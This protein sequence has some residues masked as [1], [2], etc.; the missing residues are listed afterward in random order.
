M[1]IRSIVVA[2]LAASSVAFTGACAGTSAAP[3]SGGGSSSATLE[4][5]HA[6]AGQADKV[7]FINWALDT[8]KKEHP[9]IQ[10]KAVPAEQ[11]SYKTKLQTAMASG[12]PP[13]VFYSLPGGYLK[14]FVDSGQVLPLDDYMAKDGWKNTFLPSSLP[15]VSFN[16]KT[17]A[18]PIDIDSAVIWYDKKLFAA[19]GW[20]PPKTWEEFQ[21]LCEKI[22]AAGVVPIALGNK[23]SWPAT[24][25]FQYAEMRLHGSGVVSDLVAGK[26]G[27]SFG[28]EA[29]QAAGVL[30]TLSQ[31]GYFPKG[32]NGMSDAE[33]NMLFLNGKAAMVLNGTWQIGMTADAPSGFD[34]GYFAFPTFAQGK[35]DQADVLAGVAA[36]FAVSQKAK[37]KEAAVAFLKFLTSEEAMK[38]YVKVRKTMVA[39]TGATTAEDAGPVLAG[40]VQDV[41]GKAPRLDAFYDTALAPKATDVYYK[42]LQGLIDGSVQPQDGAKN[43][44]TAVKA[45]K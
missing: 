30:T 20:Q 9:E 3:G 13:D 21:A 38:K 16:G 45:A 43:I 14:A 17:Y 26:P 34:L 12:N 7:E 2:A 37:N 42:T 40:V 27:A 44:E 22:K 19:H 35:G 1:R 11:S 29:A 24:F 6:Y 36:S 31:K 32:A 10:V 5:W 33:A 18:A 41:V 28:P 23:D 8:F 39:R 15:S 4:I 25:W